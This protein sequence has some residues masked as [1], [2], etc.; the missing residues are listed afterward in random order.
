MRFFSLLCILSNTS[1]LIAQVGVNTTTPAATLDVVAKNLSTTSVDGIIAPRIDRLKAFNMLGIPNGTLIYIND[2]TTGLASGQTVNVNS[3][4]YYYFEG[5]VW[6]K[7]NTGIVAPVN[8]YNSDGAL[9]GNRNVNLASNS[10]SWNSNA[11]TTNA[12]NINTVS[13]TTGTALN[14]VS[15]NNTGNTNGV[16][17]VL[18]TSAAGAGTFATFQ[19]NN[20]SE[21]GI[22]ILNSGNVGVG[23][24][25]PTATFHVNGTGRITN[26]PASTS[27][28]DK[29]LV[30]DTNGNVLSR[31]ATVSRIGSLALNGTTNW[32]A[33]P[34]ATIL[35]FYFIDKIHTITLPT[36]PNSSFS[37]KLIRFYVYGGGVNNSITFNGVYGPTSPGTG[38]FPSGFSYSGQGS[39]VTLTVTGESNRFSFIDIISD[40]TNWWV[41][42][43]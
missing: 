6:Q 4:G 34:A 14:V 1:L 5:T 41:D 43:R 28:S 9:N 26:T 12:I 24:A 20:T 36:M 27:T 7:L 16:I 37:G 29:Y 23:T 2:I 25:S 39:N 17:K 3:T 11:T 19:A 22:N 18:N 8:I 10:I 31:S 42:N 15:T 40:G 30:V 13:L 33:T 21:S 32:S 38:I 35:D